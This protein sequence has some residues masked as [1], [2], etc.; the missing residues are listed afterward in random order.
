LPQASG[1]GASN[2]ARRAMTVPTDPPCAAFDA[3]AP[4]VAAKEGMA[5]GAV[6]WRSAIKKPDQLC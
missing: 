6:S 5:L 3:P 1:S 4:V 2:R